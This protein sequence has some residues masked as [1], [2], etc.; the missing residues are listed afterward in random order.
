MALYI[1]VH[2]GAI[3]TRRWSLLLVCNLLLIAGVSAQDARK[4]KKVLKNAEI[5][6]LV[7]SHFD[8][9]TLVK[10]IEVSDSDFDISGDALITLE[11]QGVSAT[12]IRA[13]V[14]AAQRSRRAA[15]A[16]PA[17]PVDAPPGASG[18]SAPGAANADT[19]A[20]L[21]RDR[22]K[23]MDP[24]TA[25]RSMSMD[26]KQLAGLPAQMSAM[27]MGGMFS[28]SAYSP[29]Q[30]PHVFLVALTRQEIAPSTAEI[31]Q[32]NLK[33][34]NPSAGGTILR[35]LATQ[36]LSFASMAAPGM[37][38]MSA[39]SMA[40][41]FMPGMR[42]GRP[43]F[44]YV[45]G[46]PGPRSSR[47]LADRTPRFELSYGEIPGVDPDR[48]EP[49]LVKL[50][51]TKDNY[52]LVGATRTKMDNKNVMSMSPENGTWISEE[53]WPMH[54]AKEERG[55]YVMGVERPLEPGEYA[56]V[57][58]PVKGYKAAPSGFGGA[59]QVFYSVWDFSVPGAPMEGSGEKKKK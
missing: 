3:M 52:R 10:L 51:P 39:F 54:L 7:K 25:M 8:D 11:N 45:W 56:I 24:T 33:S 12:V 36:G 42:P 38:A 19:P 21:T 30:M 1:R 13:M 18:P 44:T 31:A 57:L 6:L 53:R 2:R 55:F 20:M 47:E 49:A 17:N 46:L 9:E 28:T 4:E 37:M 41:G 16:P 27:N 50:F 23:A 40:S 48:Y 15:K 59:A 32:T 29:E 35:S 26:P 58:R 5:V 34:G 22:G 43:S 14:E